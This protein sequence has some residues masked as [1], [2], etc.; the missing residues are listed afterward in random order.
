MT[1][2]YSNFREIPLECKMN[3]MLT[4]FFFQRVYECPILLQLGLIM[5]LFP[6]LREQNIPF[7]FSS[8]LEINSFQNKV[9]EWPDIDF[10]KLV[11]CYLS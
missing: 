6:N 5:L 4:L 11:H 3:I 9:Y 7:Q 2:D 1:R 10:F 8:H